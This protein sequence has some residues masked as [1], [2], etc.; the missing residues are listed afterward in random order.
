MSYGK[1]PYGNQ[2]GFNQ[3]PQFPQGNQFA[4]PGYNQP[5]FQQARVTSAP[6]FTQP[7]FNQGPQSRKTKVPQSRKAG[8]TKAGVTKAGVTKAKVTKAR[9][10]SAPQVSRSTV[11]SR[12]RSDSRDSETDE[13]GDT[14]MTNSPFNKPAS[15]YMPPAKPSTSNKP[16]GISVY[17]RGYEKDPDTPMMDSDC[18]GPYYQDIGSHSHAPPGPM[19]WLK[20]ELKE[21]ERHYEEVQ[22][23]KRL[24]LPRYEWDSD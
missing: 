16:V 18:N 14:N 11:Q 22:R 15:P 23:K 19:P 3:F 12:A 8:V 4:Q 5:Q 1:G 21:D 9:V 17:C 6:Q 24:G 7:G 2:P 10:T 13:D 20:E